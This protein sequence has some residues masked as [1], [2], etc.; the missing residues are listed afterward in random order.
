[1]SEHFRRELDDGVLTITFTRDDKLNAVSAPM[2]AALRGAVADLGD[3]DA[4]RVL[5]IT[6]E[7]RHFTAGMDITTIDTSMGFEPDGSVNGRSVRRTYRALHLL[8]D[9][10]EAIEKPVI[11]AAQGPCRGF[12]VELAVSC[13]FRF[14]AP[15]TTFALPEVPN[16]GVLPGSGGI[17]RL[18]RLV[19]PH[20][21]RWLAMAARPVDAERALTIGL[22]HD[23]FTDEEFAASV[24]EFARS[25][26][27]LSPQALGL[28]KLAIDA[29]ASVDRTTARDFDRVAN[30]LLLTSEEHLAKVR[31]FQQRAAA[32]RE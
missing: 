21:A 9:E 22:V 23:V 6:A 14:A 31:A 25:L 16:L 15:R 26:V 29:A 27:A 4:V 7:G 12:G 20:W 5:V 2:L 19:G 17:S 28:A 32:P 3:D 13:D 18:T 8:M 30:T 11:L 24:R 10:I 1:M